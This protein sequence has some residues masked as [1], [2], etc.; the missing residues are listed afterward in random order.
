VFPAV[1]TGNASGINMIWRTSPGT[2]TTNPVPLIQ[3]AINVVVVHDAA[4]FTCTLT[5]LD[6]QPH[7]VGL[8]FAQD[9]RANAPI[10][11]APGVPPADGPV[12]LPGGGQVS[13]AVT[14]DGPQIPASWIRFIGP[15]LGTGATV[16]P[17]GSAINFAP[18]DRLIF[19][20]A[21]DIISA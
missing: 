11:A 7:N 16:R 2:S 19:G 21:I 5:N 15:G 6:S 18:P 14:F 9:F 1:P 20:N 10:P 13:T 17:S 8:R 4:Q 12:L 3:V